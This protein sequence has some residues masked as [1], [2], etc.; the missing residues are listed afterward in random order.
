MILGAIAVGGL[1]TGPQLLADPTGAAI[2]ADAISLEGTPL[3]DWYLVGWFLIVVMGIVPLVIAWGL[4][5]RHGW[6]LAE[7]LDPVGS[8][9]WSWFAT[10]AFGAGL[11]LW[12]GLQF[13][14]IEQKGG[15]QPLFLVLGLALLG[16]PWLPGVRR[17]LAAPRG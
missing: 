10:E 3:S 1:A 8:E 11:L 5:T 4:V 15:P 2:G 9:H 17:D 13:A 6:R 14:L 7:R 16:L 12:I